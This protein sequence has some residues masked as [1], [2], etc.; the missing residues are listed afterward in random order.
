MNNTMDNQQVTPYNL[1]WLSGI[2]DGEGTFAIYKCPRKNKYSYTGRLTLSNTDM[3]MLDEIFRIFDYYGITGHICEEKRRKKRKNHKDCYHITINK[4]SSVLNGI[5][6]MLPY[7]VSKKAHAQIVKRFVQSR[8]KYKQTVKQDKKTGRLLGTIEK[9][10]TS[11][12]ISF[13]EQVKKLN[14]KGN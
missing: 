5:E 2:W 3:T 6:L 10:Y 4:M 9:G 8:I 13:Y 7:L 11:E 14:K 12:E 1:A